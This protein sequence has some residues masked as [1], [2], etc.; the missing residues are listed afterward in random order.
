MTRTAELED[1]MGE[2]A[3]VTNVVGMKLSAD[4]SRIVGLMQMVYTW[5]VVAGVDRIGFD[6]RW[7]FEDYAAASAALAAWDGNRESEPQGWH[8]HPRTGRRRTKGNP[9]GEYILP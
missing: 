8:R 5:A 9:A 1:L 6:D 3:T 4:R 7:C 2:L